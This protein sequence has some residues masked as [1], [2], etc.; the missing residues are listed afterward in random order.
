MKISRI[1][2]AALGIN[3]CSVRAMKTKVPT[4]FVS[5]ISEEAELARVLKDEIFAAFG[6]A[7]KVFVSSDYESIDVG[8][9]WLGSIQEALKGAGLELILCSRLSIT[10]PWV[11]FELGAAW[12]KKIPI[13]PICHSGLQ[14]GD[15]PMPYSALNAV[16]ADQEQGLRK[17]FARISKITGIEPA[18]TDFPRLVARVQ[19]FEAAY[20]VDVRMRGQAGAL[21]D[22]LRGE[23]IVGTWLGGG[24]DLEIPEFLTYKA[25]LSYELRLELRR[26][27]NQIVGEMHI[28]PNDMDSE[29]VAF[30][31]MINDSGEYFYFKYWLAI[32]HANHCGFMLLQLS[33]LG[34]EL[35]GMFMTN[36][37]RER[38]IGLGQINFR[39]R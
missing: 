21:V 15:L 17:L 37:I 2:P 4:I 6:S 30:M 34:D 27:Q 24:S 14:P 32:P 9:E 3:D 25:K 36:K 16:Q 38:Q 10:R 23:R 22:S 5:H 31:E 11:N 18:D 19:K 28:R 7:V 8:A 26:H 35:E 13:I 33:V 29:H 20:V 39:R 12:L 1:S